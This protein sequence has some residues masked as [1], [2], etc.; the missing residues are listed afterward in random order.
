MVTVKHVSGVVISKTYRSNEQMC[1]SASV[2]VNA[3]A[4]SSWAKPQTIKLVLTASLLDTEHQKDS[5]KKPTR[6]LFQAVAKNTKRHFS[7][8]LIKT[9]SSMTSSLSS[10][11][12]KM[13]ENKDHL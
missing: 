13:Q 1:M 10:N 7:V 2:A 11:R 6:L 5:V 4:N 9:S 8:F 3:G 12:I